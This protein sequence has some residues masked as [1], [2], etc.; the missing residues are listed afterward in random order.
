MVETLKK[1]FLKTNKELATWAASEALDAILAERPDLCGKTAYFPG[2]GMAAGHSAGGNAHVIF[3]G[4]E[5]FKAPRW[6][7]QGDVAFFSREPEVLK[8]LEG[9]GLPIPR[10]T[11]I[12]RDAPFFGMTRMEGI[13]IPK[14]F[15]RTFS[16]QELR[17]LARDLAAFAADMASALPVNEKG[18]VVAHQDLQTCN[19]LIDPETKKLMAVIDFGITGYTLNPSVRF[20]DP[21]FERIFCEEYKTRAAR[22]FKSC[23]HSCEV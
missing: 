17:C 1:A 7:S 5:V 9:R 15:Y 18:M 22:I 11:C 14:D 3:I 23:S 8:Q 10:V 16:P 19:V 12:G 4:D 20:D 6:I 2:Q 13:T 21:A